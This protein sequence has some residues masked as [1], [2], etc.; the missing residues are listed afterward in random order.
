M[1]PS[2]VLVALL[3]IL[4]AVPNASAQSWWRPFKA[5]QTAAS[6]TPNTC[7]AAG[8]CFDQDGRPIAKPAAKAPTVTVRAGSYRDDIVVNQTTSRVSS[9]SHGGRSTNEQLVREWGLPP[10]SVIVGVSE[11]VA[12]E[13]P[14]QA[15]AGG[16]CRCS[17]ECPNCGTIVRCDGVNRSAD[18]KPGFDQDAS[19]QDTAEGF[20]CRL[21]ESDGLSFTPTEAEGFAFRLTLPPVEP[22][23]MVATLPETLNPPDSLVALK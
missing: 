4:L 13:S 19:T 8:V 21:A 3:A 6:G 14:P 2:T 18:A 1:K 9:G 22:L 10:G 23:T 15:A 12:T 11:G 16:E 7:N 20:A 17:G 5:K